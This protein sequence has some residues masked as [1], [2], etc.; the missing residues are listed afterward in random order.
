MACNPRARFGCSRVRIDS[1]LLLLRKVNQQ[2]AVTGRQ[3]SHTMSAGSHGDRQLV[4]AG[5]LD[6][7]RN[8]FSRCASRNNRGEPIKSSIPYL[9]GRVVA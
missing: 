7:P 4:T 2:A 6:G 5:E 1:Y 9:S 3:T 8:V